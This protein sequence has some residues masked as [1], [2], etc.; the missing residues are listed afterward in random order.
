MTT[1][2][3]VLN[4]IFPSQVHMSKA[5]GKEYVEN[6]FNTKKENIARTKVEKTEGIAAK[7]D[8]VLKDGNNAKAK[9][10]SPVTG[11]KRKSSKNNSGESNSED[12]EKKV[13]CVQ[14]LTPPLSPDGKDGADDVM[15]VM[16]VDGVVVD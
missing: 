12:E 11:S 10:S 13:A 9:K 16:S 3:K 7:V 14:P 6:N 4:K 5:H 8:N 2:E 15:A 1:S